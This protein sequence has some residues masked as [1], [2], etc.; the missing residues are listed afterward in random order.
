M[1]RFGPNWPALKGICRAPADPP[2]IVGLPPG[3]GPA[4][5][6][7]EALDLFNTARAAAGLAPLEFDPRVGQAALDHSL[8]MARTGFM[9]HPGSDGT[10]VA[11]RLE[12]AGFQ[13]FFVA[14]N[15]A[16]GYGDA[17]G[18]FAGWMGSKGHRENIL[19][20]AT[21]GAVARAGPEEAAYWTAVFAVPQ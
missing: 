8:D 4:R 12:R 19:S 18:V 9:G 13:W 10:S 11:Q 17:G 7:S 6:V 14:E 5:L 1:R 16:H 3:D 2:T 15:V 21:L 20:K